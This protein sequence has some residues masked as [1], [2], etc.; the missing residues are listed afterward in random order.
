MAG[1]GRA[2]IMPVHRIVARNAE[3]PAGNDLFRRHSRTRLGRLPSRLC[4]S[5]QA[6]PPYKRSFPLAVRGPTSGVCPS[7]LRYTRAAAGPNPAR[8]VL[9]VVRVLNR[10]PVCRVWLGHLPF[11]PG[12]LTLIRRSPVDFSVPSVV[13]GTAAL[14]PTRPALH[15]VLL[16]RLPS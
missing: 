15:S 2:T 13:L 11:K 3:A 14:K 12:G 5:T 8:S 9:L 10:R 4:S 6:M 16:S 1:R 7:E